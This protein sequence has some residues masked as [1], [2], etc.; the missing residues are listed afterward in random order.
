MYNSVHICTIKYMYVQCKNRLFSYEVFD[1]IHMSQN[2]HGMAL[3][4]PL[5]AYFVL[6]I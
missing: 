5:H 4:V 1:L 6:A 3:L 2:I